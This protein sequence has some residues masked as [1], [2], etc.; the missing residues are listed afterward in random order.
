[1]T[2]LS[3]LTCVKD[4]STTCITTTT[5]IPAL[6]SILLVF[7]LSREGSEDQEDNM[8]EKSGIEKC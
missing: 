1:M 8:E 3:N 6:A 7:H 2:N 4:L 5:D